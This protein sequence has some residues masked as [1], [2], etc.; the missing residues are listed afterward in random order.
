M[1]DLSSKMEVP[2]TW[3]EDAEIQFVLQEENTPESPHSKREDIIHRMLHGRLLSS[4][5]RRSRHVP[6][7]MYAPA[8]LAGWCVLILLV[9]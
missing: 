2:Y 6:G 7:L 9:R 1:T 5:I 3:N 4:Q 8:I